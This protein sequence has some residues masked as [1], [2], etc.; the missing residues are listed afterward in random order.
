MP[1]LVVVCLN[2]LLLVASIFAFVGFGLVFC[3]NL[4]AVSI[5]QS[6]LNTMLT[7]HLV[8]HAFPPLFVLLEHSL[9]LVNGSLVRLALFFVALFGDGNLERATGV[10]ELTLELFDAH[11]APAER[12]FVFLLLFRVLLFELGQL[13]RVSCLFLV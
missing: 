7:H 13:L 4:Y 1:E 3:L 6:A 5:A 8:L 11:V 9:P 12:H 2:P 10:L